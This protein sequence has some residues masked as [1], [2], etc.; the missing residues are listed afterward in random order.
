[1]VVFLMAGESDCITWG[2]TLPNLF[3]EEIILMTKRKNTRKVVI[4]DIA[5]LSAKMKREEKICYDIPHLLREWGVD[6][7]TRVLATMMSAAA[8]L[9]GAGII[10]DFATREELMLAVLQAVLSNPVSYAVLCV[11]I[12]VGLSIVMGIDT[13]QQHKKDYRYYR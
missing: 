11:T 10:V 2:H 6:I 13:I 1:M 3:T 12:F 7:F 5:E 4:G 8:I 9:L